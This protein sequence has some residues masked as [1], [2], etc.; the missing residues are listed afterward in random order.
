VAFEFGP[1]DASFIEM[2]L[3]TLPSTHSPMSD[4]DM[5][6]PT[7]EWDGSDSWIRK[8]FQVGAACHGLITT[9]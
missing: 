9:D 7:S 4:V 1:A 6:E 3:S 5:L 2:V 8:H